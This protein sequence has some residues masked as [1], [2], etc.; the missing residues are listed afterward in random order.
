MK[1]LTSLLIGSLLFFSVACD[2]TAKTTV[3]APDSGE[4]PASP[5]AQTTQDAK[6]DAQSELRRRQ[7]NSD[8]RARE[9]RNLATGD[10]T[11][12]AVK[13]L[14]S[15]VRSKLEANIPGGQL[16]VKATQDGMVTV[17]GTVSNQDQLAKIEPLA[18]EIN[19]VKNVVVETIV[20]PPQN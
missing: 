9:E 8:I 2:D 17:S 4:V 3:T 20:A 14:A 15:E 13:D 6:E 10:I 16:T 11:D 5:A 19:G 18:K 1:K 7:L 12:R